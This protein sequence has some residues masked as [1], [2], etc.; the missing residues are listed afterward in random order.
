V[1]ADLPLIPWPIRTLSIC[2]SAVYLYLIVAALRRSRMAVRQ[3]V[4][5]LI[6]GI[7]FLAVS[8]Y[9]TPVLRLA[10]WLGFV[11]PS[12]AGFIVWLLSLTGL[13]FYQSVTT[14]RHAAQIKTLSQE[15]ALREAAPP[16]ATRE[17]QP[18]DSV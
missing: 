8:L 11:A 4:L 2:A 17:L 13:A 14:S 10:E 16:R 6:S 12:N 1:I 9:P 7:A 3:S 15:L 18:G 5:W